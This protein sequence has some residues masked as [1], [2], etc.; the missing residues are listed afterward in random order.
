MLS[1]LPV[2]I[3]ALV[4]GKYRVERVLGRGGM[5]IVVA[6]R[7]VELNRLFAIKLMNEAAPRSA[8]AIERFKREALHAA[9]LKSEHVTQV[10]DIGNLADGS[11]FLVMEHLEGLD[12]HAI[13]QREGAQP[14]Q[15]SALYVLQACEAVAE[16][17]AAGILHRDLKPANLF[18]TWRPNG[19]PCVKVLDFGLSKLI[20]PEIGEQGDPLT[21]SNEAMGTP[22]YMS[23]E[24]MRSARDVDA[25]TDVWALGVILYELVT[26]KRP[27]PGSSYFDIAVL[28]NKG[29]PSAPSSHRPDLP[30]ELEAIIL[31]CLE[32]DPEQR[33]GSAAALLRA[34]TP[35]AG[36]EPAREKEPGLSNGPPAPVNGDA[37][38]ELQG[39]P[40][41]AE[42][43][44]SDALGAERKRFD[45]F[46]SHNRVDRPW[47]LRL[48]HSLEKRGLTVGL[49]RDERAPE[50]YLL[51]SRAVA[52]LISPESLRSGW[53]REAYSRAL[54]L[55]HDS[56]DRAP[57]IPVLL[58]DAELPSFLADSAWVDLRDGVLFEPGLDKLA[59]GATGER[60]K[61]TSMKPL[62]R[63]ALLD[64]R[65]AAEL[66]ISYPPRAGSRR[67]DARSQ[68]ANLYALSIYKTV[69]VENHFGS[70]LSALVM[71]DELLREAVHFLPAEAGG[72][73]PDLAA[74]VAEASS[75]WLSDPGFQVTASVYGR[76][77]GS[78]TE[79]PADAVAYLQRMLLLARRFDAAI[80]PH[81]DRWR[82]YHY[83]FENCL[84]HP[85]GGEPRQ[86]AISLPDPAAAA[87]EAVSAQR[88]ARISRIASRAP[89][90]APPVSL[91]RYGP[92][93][94]PSPTAGAKPLEPLSI[95]PAFIYEL[96]V[97]GGAEAT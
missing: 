48:K 32:K 44:A 40:A 91:V 73:P 23:P 71:R 25:R 97:A 5:G 46:L 76:S 28:V 67:V 39:A 31:R 64:R 62:K 45:L 66:L 82:L 65:L 57:I 42:I 60:P 79:S 13:L 49:D 21:R 89:R 78:L 36:V 84:P 35:F 56:A 2:Q 34:L 74:A 9:R 92:M 53:V 96:C 15:R 27:F 43:T 94:Y 72:E 88:S 20:S 51:D 83:W 18:L 19:T 11:P 54:V 17:H 93:I 38:T 33:I 12:L 1:P 50:Q 24:Q 58:P 7:H 95:Y 10:F 37:T 80:I 29:R 90:A 30:P 59:W 61:A 86:T 47:A 26:G 69:L 8:T 87:A 85:S 16:A 77:K 55:R 3:G 6:C 70:I 22:Y 68:L 63:C 4:A 41:N 14:I 75:A 52:L 81:P